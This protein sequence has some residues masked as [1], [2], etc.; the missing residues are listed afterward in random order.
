MS[1]SRQSSGTSLGDSGRMSRREA[2]SLGACLGAGLAIGAPTLAGC[3]G[4][5]EPTATGRAEVP[6][7]SAPTGMLRPAH[8]KNPT[9]FDPS[10]ADG[11][12]LRLAANIYE[13]L[14]RFKGDGS[15]V[16]GELAESF[17][18]SPD[19]REWV[20]RLK[21]GIT[22]HDGEPLT[23]SAVKAS[24][25]Y[26]RRDGTTWPFVAPGDATFD[27]SDP[28]TVRIA[29]KA[30]FP[31]MA[32]GATMIRIISPRLIAAGADAVNKRPAG[33]GPFKFASFKNSES[34]VLEANER[35]RGPGPYLESLEFRII[36][37]PSSR[38]AALRAGGVDLVTRM[39]PTDAVPLRSD[40]NF[41]VTEKQIWEQVY[42]IF[43]VDQSPANNLKVRQAIAHAID[44]NAILKALFAGVG[45]VNDSV[46]PPGIYGYKEPVTKY[47][48]DPQR[49]RQLISESGL[50]TPINM[51][52]F[53]HE[54]FAVQIERVQTLISSMV[55]D[56]GINLGVKQLP[57][58]EIF[59]ILGTKGKVPYQGLSGGLGWLTGG[60][61]YFQTK[62]F[63]TNARFHA[64]D[65]LSD[66]M[67]T[68][69][70]GPERQKLLA[71]IQEEFAQQLP[72]IPL[73]TVTEVDAHKASVHGYSVPQDGNMYR[74]GEV[75]VGGK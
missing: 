30:P 60:P 68:T 19:A 55:K 10:L 35:Y 70:D 48:Y 15:D 37:D 24:F 54:A 64:V 29:T 23:S 3:S 39:A 44:R 73:Y 11:N 27:V 38:V 71:D 5:G 32:R 2:L 50:P 63:R 43:F 7:P 33:T 66:K 21:D 34:I 26:W 67:L 31:E 47:P 6:P 46:L 56:V 58:T 75:Y 17:E 28:K 59:K 18:S 4:G 69:R 36:P 53:W 42:L 25:E 14:T 74:F 45:T 49:A 41:V 65:D 20:F 22:F 8:P 72:V 1:S 61:L 57:I 51:E 12:D 9:S 13:G 16:E 62:Y 52:I 40:R